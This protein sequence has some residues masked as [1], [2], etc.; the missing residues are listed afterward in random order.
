MLGTSA[1]ALLAAT[2]L[3]FSALT[4]T[5]LGRYLIWLQPTNSDHLRMPQRTLTAS[6]A[7]V[8][9]P[10]RPLPGGLDSLPIQ[11]ST[12]EPALPLAKL[13]ADSGTTALVVLHQGHVVWEHYP[14]GGSRQRLNRCFSV[15]KS[16][17]SA[18]VGTAVDAG[19]IASVEDPVGKY[20]DRIARSSRGS[21]DHRSPAGNALG[22][23][24]RRRLSA[25]E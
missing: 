4:S 10:I 8:A 14:N 3:P 11:T 17:A 16:I 19:L 20:F 13:L 22:N 24:L 6:P 15:T 5:Y 7:P 2:S 12:G 1:A 25:V 9:L 23:S 21:T 18:L